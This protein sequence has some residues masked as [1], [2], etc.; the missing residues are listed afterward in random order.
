V[1]RG[2]IMQQ[3]T[4]GSDATKEYIY[5]L[6]KEFMKLEVDKVYL[7]NHLEHPKEK[8]ALNEWYMILAE[9]GSVEETLTNQ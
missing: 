4:V 6:Q 7:Y 1:R 5:N 8:V 3:A 9:H 2:F